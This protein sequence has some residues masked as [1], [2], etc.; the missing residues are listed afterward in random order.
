M[1]TLEKKQQ[2]RDLYPDDWWALA[3]K[4]FWAETIASQLGPMAGGLTAGAVT[5][6]AGAVIGPATGVALFGLQGAGGTYLN[7]YAEAIAERCRGR[8]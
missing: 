3:D 4:D 5:G 7:T 6:P 8:P 2:L 1:K